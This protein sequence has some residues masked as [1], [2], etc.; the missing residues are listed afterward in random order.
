MKRNASLGNLP[1]KG[2]KSTTNDQQE[3]NDSGE[4]VPALHRDKQSN[5]YLETIKEIEQQQ[6]QH[7]LQKNAQSVKGR[8]IKNQPLQRKN[9]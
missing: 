1:A 6:Y 3:R 9:P 8:Q 4:R 5:D 2:T 7:Q